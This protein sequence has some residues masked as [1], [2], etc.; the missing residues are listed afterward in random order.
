MCI[1]SKGIDMLKNYVLLTIQAVLLALACY[2]MLV[3][4][5][6]LGV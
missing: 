1:A 5:M 2:G 4:M 6:A 3:M